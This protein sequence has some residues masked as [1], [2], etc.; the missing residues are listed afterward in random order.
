LYS[1]PWRLIGRRVDAR[2]AGDMVQIFDGGDVVATHVRRPSGRATDFNHYPPERIAFTMRTPTWCRNTAAEVGP[3]AMEVI[4]ELMA[5]NAIHHLRAAQGILG[6]R[7]KHGADLLE[8][9]CARAL[10]VGDPGYRTIKGIAV[11]AETTP[12]ASTGAAADVPAFLRGPD[13][14]GTDP[15][16]A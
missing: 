6:L 8:A 13:Q 3:A 1:V 12:P 7:D 15:A 14:F 16:I 10:E 2:T 5:D 9:A 4:A 11:G